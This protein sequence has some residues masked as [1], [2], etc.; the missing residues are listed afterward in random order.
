MTRAKLKALC[1]HGQ[2]KISDRL[3]YETLKGFWQT[4]IY[5]VFKPAASADVLLNRVA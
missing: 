4:S 1:L 5:N 2:A 3:V